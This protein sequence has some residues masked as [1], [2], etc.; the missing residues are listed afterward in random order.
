[1]LLAALRWRTKALIAAPLLLLWL[2]G[3]P[4][5]SDLLM[6]SLEDRFPHRSNDECPKSDAVF[7]FGGMLGLRAHVGGGIEWNEASERFYRAVDL[8][9][10]GK[11]RVMVL[12]GGPESYDG[13]PDEG[14]LLKKK[15]SRWAF[16]A[17]QLL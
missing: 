15:Q 13:G 3:V 5:I 10:A 16:P 6:R 4:V 17:A 9:K 7:I 8:Y 12:S 1:M 11:A 14:E 2:F